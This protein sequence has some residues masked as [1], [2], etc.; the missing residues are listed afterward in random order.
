MA[1]RITII[2]GGS[3]H[4]APRLLA[5]FAN[6][7]ALA[8][9]HVVLHDIDASKL[10]RMQA[11]GALLAQR[12]GIG[13]SVTSETDR[14]R[15]LDGSQFVVACL[16]VGGFESMAN[17][18]EIPERHGMR[19]PIGD[20]VG[21]G[22]VMRALRS[23]PVVL[24]IAR[25]IEAVCPD[26]LFLNVSNP[27]TALCRAVT[28]ETK[29]Q[30]IGLCNELVGMQYVMS[31]LLDADM[32]KLDPVVG[33]VNHLPLVTELH[34]ADGADA[35]AALRDLLDDPERAARETMWMDPPPAMEY[36]KITPGDRWH[37]AD[38][39]HNNQ[40][41]L[42]LFHRFGVLPGSGDHHLAEFFP[43]FVTPENDYGSEW[44]VHIYGLRKHMTD[45]D[46]DVT[47]YEAV[48][49][50]DDVSRFPSGELVAP[51]LEAIVT[52]NRRDLPVNLPN[53][54][55]VANLPD[56]VVVEA[57]GTVDADGVR[58]R[59]RVEVPSILGEYLRRVAVSQELTVDAALTGDR[60]TV[61]E[62]MLADPMAGRLPYET[63]ATMTEDMLIAT[64]QWLP[65]F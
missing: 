30:A 64:A 54:G 50:L 49:D 25:D 48:R 1:P 46:D 31:L 14:R 3:Y 22:G 26:A 63:V 34:D 56:G 61:F 11:L 4:W 5:D 33:G 60:T 27:L 2:G 18:L 42:E 39:I 47:H 13:L 53:R 17:D 15:A 21:P 19:Q 57:M 10:P 9:S 32:R 45:A 38:V 28:R 35:L 36:E 41:R 20:T 8:D 62:A 23:V 37:K 29:V 6:T 40:V 44:K 12:R 65:Q 59:D 51:L 43:G 55:Q 16:S 58:A 24:D 7:P 52:G